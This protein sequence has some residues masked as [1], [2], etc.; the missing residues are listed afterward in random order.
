MT[1]RQDAGNPG[2]LGAFR[3]FRAA[4]SLRASRLSAWLSVRLADR[5][6]SLD[7]RLPRFLRTAGVDAL[8]RRLWNWSRVRPIMVDGLFAV[9]LLAMSSPHLALHP[10][11]PPVVGWLLQP[12]LFLPLVFRRHTPVAVFGV[13]ASIAFVQL[14]MGILL[15]TGDLALL[16]ALYSVA[17]HSLPRRM[18]AA[19]AVLEF[20]VLL[21]THRWADG[22]NEPRMFLLL[23]GMTTAAAVIGLNVRTRR[24]YLASLEERARRLEFE[25]DQQARIA[26]AA[27]RASIA[28][29]V[30]DVVTH[31]LSVMV[32]LTDGASFA[33]HTAPDRAAEAVGKASEVGRQAIADMQRVIGVLRAPEETGVGRPD[34]E[35]QPGLARLDTLLSEVRAAGLPVELVVGGTPLELGSGVELAVYRVVQEALTNIRKHAGEGVA[36]RV[37]LRF[38]P[39]GVEVTVLDDGGTAPKSARGTAQPAARPAHLT[40]QAHQAHQLHPAHPTPMTDPAHADA[41]PLGGYGIAGMRERVAVYGGSLEAG[42]LRG[43]GGWRVSARIPVQDGPTLETQV[44]KEARP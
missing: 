9:F 27:E 25:R 40:Y 19:A 28:R 30:H 8:V 13:I 21:A 1:S 39:D 33:I 22:R 24:A 34:L 42:P 32:A 18:V 26:A 16:I 15:P 41:D 14:L 2:A 43:N 29:E 36:S 6:P 23:S 3:G 44:Q 35:P 31:S 20:G 7:V 37:L 11:K 12:A 4:W 17:A 10:T 5:V 38:E